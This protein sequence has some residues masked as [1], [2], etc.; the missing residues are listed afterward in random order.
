MRIGHM[1]SRVS[2]H[3]KWAGLMG[4]VCLALAGFVC[5]AARAATA[6]NAK[7]PLAMN[8]LNVNYYTGEQPF[9]NLFKTTGVAQSAPNGWFT[10]TVALWDTGEAAYLQLDANG[11][12]TT[13]TAG[14]ADPHSPQ[15]FNRVSV[16]LERDLGKSNSGT[17][18]PYR[19]GQ[20]VVTYSGRG[21]LAYS[22]DATL[23]SSSAGRD[24]INV[25]TPS[26]G[27]IV[28]Q[29]TSTDP[30][31]TGDYV[32]NIQVVK[33]EEQGLLAAGNVFAPGFLTLMQN[34]RAV[35]F[36]QWLNM[37]SSG[38]NLA[39]WSS[40]PLP[41]DAGWGGPNGVPIELAVQL[42]NALGSD[43]WLNV[44]HQASNDYITKMATLVHTA[45]GTGQNAY[46]ELSNEV[47]N[48]SFPQHS[49]AA[50]QGQAMWPN[51]GSR[52]D[53]G[54]N[55]YGMRVAQMCDLWKAAWGADSSRVICVMGAQ[56]GNAYTAT[57]SLNCAL[58]TG[59]G[60]APCASHGIGAVAVSPYLFVAPSAS[61]TA[62]PDGGLSQLFAALNGSLNEVSAGEAQYKTAIAPYH[63]PLIA[64]EGGQSLVG[65]STPAMQALFVAANRD[66]RM[67][68]VYTTLLNDWKTNGGQMFAVYASIYAPG[69]YG[70]WGALESF[71][72]TVIPLTSAP[73]KWQA[74]QN[75]ISS[76][77]CWW[78]GCA[79][80]IG[81]VK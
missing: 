4:V 37:N 76:T 80:T 56:A 15:L 17:G 57:T 5:T 54:A 38:G 41:T 66:P 50:A 20:Y 19:S 46:V 2:V 12:P 36:M 62:A 53:Y 70:E 10:S 81:T 51:A 26:S 34:F 61:W 32:R 13:L 58:W 65:A 59:A 68:V 48:G 71:M 43:C 33:A 52:A 18:P 27:G 55:W 40:R 73:P 69:Q 23:V 21:T 79:G 14:S 64:Y 24:V 8:L 9:L 28:L 35:R 74:L 44:P 16:L 7:S 72:D 63:L 75:F 1:H 67:Q 39:N 78:S 6:A 29:I 3:R 31:H 47:W 49:Y 45:L 30:N 60:N 42:C 11:Y 77:P 22:G 25:A